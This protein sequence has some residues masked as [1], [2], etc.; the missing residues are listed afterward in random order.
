M[1]MSMTPINKGLR[2]GFVLPMALVATV[3]GMMIVGASAFYCNTT[4]RTS[5]VYLYRTRCRLAAQSTLE[6][7]KLSLERNLVSI[8]D[9]TSTE[10][11][12]SLSA[13]ESSVRGDAELRRQLE[14]LTGGDE[15]LKITYDVKSEDGFDSVYATA[16]YSFGGQTTS[17]TLREDVKLNRVGTVNIFD[18][19]YF[20]NN[21]GHLLSR[22]LTVNGD[23]R[24]NGNFHILGGEI[25][26]FVYYT[27]EVY[28]ATSSVF[29]LLNLTD[30]KT[31]IVGRKR[32]NGGSAYRNNNYAKMRPS[33]PLD[34]GTP[35]PGGYD[36]IH[37]MKTG[38]FG[39]LTWETDSTWIYP[40]NDRNEKKTESK[41][42]IP[43][44][45]GFLGMPKIIP[46]SMPE[47]AE[48]GEFHLSHYKDRA[49]AAKTPK[50]RTGGSLIC[51]NCYYNAVSKSNEQ[52][53]AKVRLSWKNADFA[54]WGLST[55][56]GA[57]QPY[58]TPPVDQSKLPEGTDP[59][60]HF[61][62]EYNQEAIDEIE[63]DRD[64]AS[65]LF[66]K[67]SIP[68]Y[69]SITAEVFDHLPDS[70][71]GNWLQLKNE[72]EK[73]SDN[74]TIIGND[75]LTGV[76]TG[77][78]NT[79][80]ASLEHLDSSLFG[81]G[82]GIFITQEELE[83]GLGELNLMDSVAAGLAR[84][85]FADEEKGKKKWEETKAD[86]DPYQ[87]EI[88]EEVK[89]TDSVMQY[90]HKSGWDFMWSSVGSGYYNPTK[91]PGAGASIAGADDVYVDGN[92]ISPIV[93]K[94]AS[95]GVSESEVVGQLLG[96]GWAPCTSGS[97][98]KLLQVGSLYVQ[99][100]R[101]Y[102]TGV[103]DRYEVR[104]GNSAK[105]KKNTLTL[106]RYTGRYYSA[107]P[108]G[109]L[110][111]KVT[112]NYIDQV[113]SVDFEYTPL[114]LDPP[115]TS[116]VVK[117]RVGTMYI[118]VRNWQTSDKTGWTRIRSTSSIRKGYRA[119]LAVGKL[120]FNQDDLDQVASAIQRSY[121]IDGAE[122]EAIFEGSSDWVYFDTPSKPYLFYSNSTVGYLGINIFELTQAGVS[123]G[124]EL[125][126][127][128]LTSA[129]MSKRQNEDLGDA[130]AIYYI[131]LHR[132]K[133]ELDLTDKSEDWARL[134]TSEYSGYPYYAPPA[135]LDASSG[136]TFKGLLA[137]CDDIGDAASGDAYISASTVF[138][139]F[140]ARSSGWSSTSSGYY[141]KEPSGYLIMKVF[142]GG[143]LRP[144]S[145]TYTYSANWGGQ[146][147]TSDPDESLNTVPPGCIPVY[148]KT[149]DAA[150]AN[151]H[152]K[153]W[154]NVAGVSGYYIPSTGKAMG[155]QFVEKAELESAIDSY[156]ESCV[157]EFPQVTKA[158][159]HDEIMK[160]FDDGG[161]LYNLGWRESNGGH[162]GYYRINPSGYLQL[163][164]F[165]EHEKRPQF[166]VDFKVLSTDAGEIAKHYDPG[167]K[168]IRA[169][170]DDPTYYQEHPEEWWRD[171]PEYGPTT[172]PVP[173][174]NWPQGAMGPEIAGE[175]VGK[176]H[177]KD[178]VT[179]EV[180]GVF[181]RGGYK[182]ITDDAFVVPSSGLPLKVPAADLI[183]T[184]DATQPKG[185]N[186]RD[187]AD[188]TTADLRPFREDPLCQCN[189]RL[190]L[191]GG[192]SAADKG[193][194]ILI[195]TWDNPIIIDGPVVFESDVIIRGFV[196][197]RGTIFSGRNIHVIGDI[198]YKNPP[199]WPV[200]EKGTPDTKGKDMLMLIARGSIVIGNYAPKYYKS[201]DYV[202]SA[203]G[204]LLSGHY[205][206]A[207]PNTSDSLS[208]YGTGSSYV[209]YVAKNYKQTDTTGGATRT[210]ILF[211]DE[212]LSETPV[213]YYES[214]I[215][216]WFFQ[217]MN[218]STGFRPDEK[219][220][221][222][223]AT[224]SAGGQ[225]PYCS[226]R[227]A[228]TWDCNFADS[229][230]VAYDPK[231]VSYQS[232][233]IESFVNAQNWGEN[234]RT[235]KTDGYDFSRF[236]L[237][238]GASYETFK[239]HC[240]ANYYGLSASSKERMNCIQEINA[241]LYASEG[242]YGVVGGKNTDCVIN[243]GIYAQDEALLPF[244]RDHRTLLSWS[245]D[246]DI[247]MTINWDIR[248]NLQS[249]EAKANGED[250]EGYASPLEGGEAKDVGEIISLSWQ[251]VPDEWNEGEQLTP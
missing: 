218:D 113:T 187:R 47:N 153:Y 157:A 178:I 66:P 231:Y 23:V 17:V 193:V 80:P 152:P 221:L 3:I 31:A 133:A 123:V 179:R 219:G 65:I 14:S 63:K 198:N 180:R 91:S 145:A 150:D 184:G 59:T 241:V 44:K 163:T 194:V 141:L 69:N 125:G 227:L 88:G 173:L 5:N 82:K 171:H 107:K 189:R 204:K 12:T 207:E 200:K 30:K 120:L 162:S 135:Y 245:T 196:S 103:P 212:R 214:V 130:S 213:K 22:E 159:V 192:G 215:G 216:D 239:S 114:H 183:L 67:G 156:A 197:G 87:K 51:S 223:L 191:E 29:N 76:A 124:H 28:L 151:R 39:L 149:T 229:M 118:P 16:A 238:G 230:P 86:F 97:Y 92:D 128:F 154:R 201:S 72:S 98:G 208:R 199:F 1:E 64:R 242:V 93:R 104:S 142:E 226:C 251:E 50:G 109:Y 181:V 40:P 243:G 134:T 116:P 228:Q 244:A 74:K 235:G 220:A 33:D 81:N 248:L 100:I 119:E 43:Q 24:C 36:P 237:S 202:D 73:Q 61:D 139:D 146:N 209:P 45:V 167:E 35:W 32:Y 71:K 168:E 203:W 185:G 247:K 11:G 112:T 217:S 37:S 62:P 53:A 95:Y 57:D 70:E 75:W 140:S 54:N 186:V 9:V 225:S 85:K 13:L 206:D 90:G 101:C 111:V 210:K 121:R 49:A 164:A 246:S 137:L 233:V 117:S 55:P 175:W 6:L 18:Y 236:G 122:V 144:A 52:F 160:M 58:D 2:K 102:E 174:S 249:A 84:A 79:D 170:Y 126:W 48:R 224:P 106:Y 8:A 115:P 148:L 131:P 34:D 205:I 96:A 250:G 232:H 26:G 129:N 132:Y 27:N 147:V 41:Q 89:Y 188:I 68:V 19:A 234:Q 7:V 155:N 56:D 165:C 172:P 94:Y 110:G 99:L 83:D 166:L 77:Y 108:A 78:E 169:G 42:R 127:E 21:N 38:F 143:F 240:Q 161:K 20:A 195:G 138:G 60:K 211:S 4:M 25:N 105:S 190:D 182:V 222:G 10:Y 15:N 158:E 176:K 46:D 177:D 136:K